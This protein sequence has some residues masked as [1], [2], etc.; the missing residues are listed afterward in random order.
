VVLEVEDCPP[1][2][3]LPPLQPQ[4]QVQGQLVELVKGSSHSNRGSWYASLCQ[5]HLVDFGRH[6]RGKPRILGSCDS[7]P[8]APHRRCLL[9]Q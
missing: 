8:T 6:P 2:E 3:D 1:V 4:G 5:N 9:L 7:S